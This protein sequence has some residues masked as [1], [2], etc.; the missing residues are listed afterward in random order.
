MNFIL[1]THVFIW[2]FLSPEKLSKKLKEIFSNEEN[3]FG[4]PTMV[5]METQYLSEVG[6]VQVELDNL[7]LVLKEQPEFTLLSFDEQVLLH[8]LKLTSNR[9]PFDRVILAHALA[10]STKILTKDRWMKKMAP[11]LVVS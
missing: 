8:A 3:I 7:M 5:L 4:V 11:H 9:D 2:R 1:D 6:R 10:T